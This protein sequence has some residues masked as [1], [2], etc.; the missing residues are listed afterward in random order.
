MTREQRQA[1]EQRQRDREEMRR[2]MRAKNDARVAELRVKAEAQQEPVTAATRERARQRV[3]ER[4]ERV[5]AAGG[6]STE[7]ARQMSAEAARRHD[8]KKAE[9]R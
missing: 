1:W 6:G 9:E 5:A 8:R 7:E 2:L 4:L 3:D